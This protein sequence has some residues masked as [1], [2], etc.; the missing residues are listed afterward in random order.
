[1]IDFVVFIIKIKQWRHLVDCWRSKNEESN[2]FLFGLDALQTTVKREILAGLPRISMAYI[3]FVN[4]TVL[5]ASGMD[6]G[7]V[8]T[9]TALASALSCILMGVLAKYPIA[10]APTLRGINAFFSYWSVLD[11]GFHG[12][13]HWMFV[14]S[15]IFI[16]ITIFKYGS[17]SLM[18]SLLI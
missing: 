15:L 17:W 18:R 1:M 9:A 5:G 2:Q 8:F 6:E 16:V 13:R 12:K 7:A 10:T 3:L 14:A 4:P 11:G